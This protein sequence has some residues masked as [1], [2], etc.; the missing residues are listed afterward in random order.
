M[1]AQQLTL[2]D[3]RVR[4]ELEQTMWRMQDLRHSLGEDQA[5]FQEADAENTA[6]RSRVGALEAEKTRLEQ[7]VWVLEAEAR[8]REWAM[9]LASPGLPA[10]DDARAAL[11]RALTRLAAD[12][13]P[14]R[15][16]DSAVAEEV[17]KRVLALRDTLTRAD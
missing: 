16:Q 11:I 8:V 17:T 7:R 14:D 6:L 12:V 13:H 4:H 5:R 15:W 2:F 9:R 1:R 10:G 3:G